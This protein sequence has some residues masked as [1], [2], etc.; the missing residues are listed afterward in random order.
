MIPMKAGKAIEEM[1]WL[2]RTVFSLSKIFGKWNNTEKIKYCITKNS[3]RRFELV[4]FWVWFQF[5][6]I[7]YNNIW[8]V[9]IF[10]HYLCWDYMLTLLTWSV[11]KYKSYIKQVI[12]IHTNYCFPV[13]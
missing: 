7:F 1:L 9:K 11:W 6:E 8:N 2:G 3:L 4:D 13:K 12:T 5:V 10:L